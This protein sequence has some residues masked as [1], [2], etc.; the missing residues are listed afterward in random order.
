MLRSFVL[1]FAALAAATSAMAQG[2]SFYGWPSGIMFR[3]YH[4]WHDS[5]ILFPAPHGPIPVHVRVYSTPLEPPYYNV[6]P[7]I[8]LDP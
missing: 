6:P 3:P 4:P 7:H 2:E 5:A 1:S 8:V